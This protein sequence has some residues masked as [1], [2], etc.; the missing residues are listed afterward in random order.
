MCYC[1]RLLVSGV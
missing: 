1:C